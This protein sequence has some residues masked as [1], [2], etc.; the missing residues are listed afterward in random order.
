MLQFEYEFFDEEQDEQRVYWVEVERFFP[1]SPETEFEPPT[2]N[3]WEYT[4]YDENREVTRDYYQE[5]LI[6]EIEYQWQMEMY[7]REYEGGD[8]EYISC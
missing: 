3:E 5:D 2:D 6:E 7:E 4:V 1:A 8:N